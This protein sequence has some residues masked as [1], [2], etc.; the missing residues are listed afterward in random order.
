MQF[1]LNIYEG[2]KT[3]YI[4]FSAKN[5][6]EALGQIFFLIKEPLKLHWELYSAKNADCDWKFV[7][8]NKPK[9][10]K[11]RLKVNNKGV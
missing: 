8:S 11:K 5:K 7:M 2:R 10:P 9:I 1:D 3:T 6:K 4:L